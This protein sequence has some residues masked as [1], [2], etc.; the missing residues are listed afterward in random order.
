[1]K[2]KIF[3]KNRA[4]RFL[5]ILVFVFS[6]GLIFGWMSNSTELS[7]LE[8]ELENLNLD[9]R[10]FNEQLA[11]A[12]AFNLEACD[13]AFIERIGESIRQSSIILDQLEKDRRT[14]T[15]RYEFLKKKHNINQVI[16]YSE[17][18]RF[19]EN[20]GYEKDIMLFF[21]DSSR[22]GQAEKQGKIID[23][24]AQGNGMLILPMDYGYTEYINYFYEYYPVEELPALV[25]NYEHILEGFSEKEAIL[26][27]LSR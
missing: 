1:M 14:T 21:F 25:I 9:L 7:E 18:K 11:F 10:S 22:P 5:I 23:S 2:K 27:A 19:K 16:Y 12:E 13:S 24:I 15:P 17:L 26:D 6:L 3:K 4:P 20:C 8:I